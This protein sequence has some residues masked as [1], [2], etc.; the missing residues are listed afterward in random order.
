MTAD[1]WSGRADAYRTIEGEGAPVHS[2]VGFD[3]T[4]T[5]LYAPLLAGKRVIM[6]PE[7][8]GLEALCAV[9]ASRKNLSLVKI[10]PAHLKVLSTMLPEDEIRDCARA[11]I[12]GGDALQSSDIA[13]WRDHSPRTRIINEYGPTETVVGCCVYDVPPGET[14]AGAVDHRALARD[15]DRFLQP[16]DHHLHVDCRREPG[17]QFDRFALDGAKSRQRKRH[18]VRA[19]PQLDDLVLSLTIGRN[20]PDF[21]NQR[22]TR[23]FHRDARKNGS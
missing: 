1:V 8:N 4:V 17:R 20:G 18:G 3:L 6:L 21:F 7:S 10:T 16:S 5:S 19:R 12:V 11:I 15:R 23:R 9:L 14:R 13:F 2:P 22:R